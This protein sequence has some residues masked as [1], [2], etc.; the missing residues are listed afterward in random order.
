[1]M[2]LNKVMMNLN[3]KVRKQKKML[4]RLM[5]ID[6]YMRHKEAAQ[7]ISHRTLATII[8]RPVPLY[9]KAN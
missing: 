2:N 3:K 1:M 7:P 5:P 6:A 8:Y 9:N 4:N